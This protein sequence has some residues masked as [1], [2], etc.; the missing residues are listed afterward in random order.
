MI[1]GEEQSQNIDF[2]EI[3]VS[4]ND[5]HLQEMIKISNQMG[6]PVVDIDGQIVIGFNKPKIDKILK[7]KQ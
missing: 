2:Q 7:I 6:V 4:K 3:D 1:S 5:E